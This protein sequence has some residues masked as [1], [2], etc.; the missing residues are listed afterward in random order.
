M[1]TVASLIQC[2]GLHVKPRFPTVRLIRPAVLA[3]ELRRGADTG[4]NIGI[5]AEGAAAV[6]VLLP[7]ACTVE[8]LLFKLCAIK[9]QALHIVRALLHIV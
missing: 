2:A 8:R 3:L 1:D 6:A 5:I 9:G 4:G 7:A